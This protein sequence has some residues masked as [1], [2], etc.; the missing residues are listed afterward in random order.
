MRRFAQN[1]IFS[2]LVGAG[3]LYSLAIPNRLLAD[4]KGS[5]N[6]AAA[7][8]SAKPAKVDAPAPGL[9]ERE[10][11]LLDRVEQL[12]KRVEELESKTSAAAPSVAPAGPSET[13]GAA[14]AAPGT[15]TAAVSPA[16]PPSTGVVK[17]A[18]TVAPG[19]LPAAPSNQDQTTSTTA[20][21]VA[22]SGKPAFVEPFSDADWTWLNG[23]PR[24]K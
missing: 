23:S 20:P 10:R 17:S 16:S 14:I 15:N 13:N 18:G 11:M 9:T 21:A 1:K 12:E 24:T 6:D 22:T 2:W 7:S 19:T 5:K 3:L 8:S 4:D